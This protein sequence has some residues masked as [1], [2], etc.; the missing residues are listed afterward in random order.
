M[1]TA[2]GLESSAAQVP[3][4]FRFVLQAPQTITHFKRLNGV[5]EEMDDFQRT[6][7]ALKRQ[8]GPL[9]FQLPPNFKKEFP[10][11]ESV[12]KLRG[13]RTSAAFEF[14]HENWFDD[15]AFACLRANFCTLC[16]ADTDDLPNPPLISTANWRDIRL[17]RAEYSDKLLKDWIKRL[18]SQPWDEAYVVFKHKDSGTGPKFAARFLELIGG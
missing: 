18:K 14:R 6:A 11:W 2:S 17:R 9:L 15:E 1:P 13:K 16:L 12:L 3:K 4:T 7:A 5:E 8:H 10:Q